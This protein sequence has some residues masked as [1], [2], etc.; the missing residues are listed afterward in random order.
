MKIKNF[1]DLEVWKLGK[2][3]CLD[4]Y[5]LTK[6]FPKDEL[7]G[8]TS[9]MRRG[10]VAIPSNVAEGFNRAHNKEYRQFLHIALGS[11]SARSP[12]G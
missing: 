3:I 7:Y 5:R 9:Q 1:R 6:P 4:V 12:S 10:A 8:L 11:C 2:A